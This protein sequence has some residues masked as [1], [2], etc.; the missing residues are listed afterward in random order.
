MFQYAIW[1]SLSIKYKTKIIFDL[2]FIK[3]RFPSNKFTLRNYELDF[4]WISENEDFSS[5]II[6]IFPILK[7]IIHPY[8]FKILNKIRFGKKYIQESWWRYEKNI[9]DNIYLDWYWQSYKYFDSIW[10]ELKEIF[11]V[12]TEIDNENQKILDL[13]KKDFLNSVSV[14]VRRW[15]YITNNNASSWH[16][17]CSVDYY[18]EAI[19]YITEKIDN[20]YFFVFSDD[21]AWVKENI[22][23]W[24]NVYFVDNNNWKWHEDLRLMYN[25]GNH[26]IANSSF[27]WWWAYLWRNEYKII[28]APKKWLQN[29]KYSFD[30]L[31]PNDWIKI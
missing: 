25:C 27:S 14:H 18:N 6:D 2:T 19:K 31:I 26:I 9:P 1:K 3:N 5:K 23:F 8:L 24:K 15:D 20:S 17:V 11:E 16:W 29:D 30:N 21:I 10:N 7:Q 28:L 22:Y 12:K 4:F 13:I